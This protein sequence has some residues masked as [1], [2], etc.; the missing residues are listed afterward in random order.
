MIKNES[1]KNLQNNKEISFLSIAEKVAEE[2]GVKL[3]LWVDL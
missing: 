3:L 1:Y 2:I